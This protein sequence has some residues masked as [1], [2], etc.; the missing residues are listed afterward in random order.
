MT[1]SKVGREEDYLSGEDTPDKRLDGDGCSAHS[2]EP[3]ALLHAS[4][5]ALNPN[6]RRSLLR[7]HW[8][9]R[10]D[11]IKKKDRDGLPKDDR[12][13]KPF[14]LE[15]PRQI[16]W[17]ETALRLMRDARFSS[18]GSWMQLRRNTFVFPS[19]HSI[20]GTLKPLIMNLQ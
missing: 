15:W 4:I 18:S 11:R 1:G 7:E 19:C 8:R 20:F 13:N 3:D 12:G 17:M 10:N 9:T 16:L 6:G 5:R 14:R 2:E